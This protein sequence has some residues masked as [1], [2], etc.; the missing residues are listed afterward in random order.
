MRKLLL[1]ICVALLASCST[2]KTGTSK[3]LDI[4]GPGVIHKPIIADLDVQQQKISYTA[5]FSRIESMQNARNEAVREALEQ[6]NA[7]VL[8]EPS[9]QS[10]TS[11]GNTELTVS[12]WPAT[13][14][15]FRQIV[16]ED[17]PLLEVKP[18]YLQKAEFNETEVE[19]K[20]SNS[21]LWITLTALVLG[22]LAAATAL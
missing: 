17:I 3:T 2:T 21:T 11:K 22:G 5:N 6:Y 15:N 19:K 13:Y 14:K 7:D 1:L 18:H 8:I 12:G 4:V 16:E 20:K 10:I 9:Y